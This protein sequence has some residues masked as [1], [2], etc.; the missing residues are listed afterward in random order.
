MLKTIIRLPDGT[1]ISSG[2]SEVNAIKEVTITQCVNSGEDLTIGSTCAGALEATLITPGGGL[3]IPADA[4]VTVLKQDGDNAPVQIGVYDLE[5]PTR[6]SANT[7][8]LTG[9]DPVAKL[10]K[11]L[12]DWLNSLSGWPYSLVDFAGKVCDACS[13]EFKK[14]DV[15][16]GS[17][18]VPQF[19]RSAVT[20]RQIMQWIGEICCRFCRADAYGNIE[21]AWYEHSGKRIDPDGELYY[22][23]NGLSYEDYETELVQAVQLRLSNSSDGALWPPASENSNSYIIVDNAIL[24]AHITES[25]IPVLNVIHEELANIKYTPCKVTV[26]ASLDIHAGSIVDIEDKNGAVMSTLVMTKTQKGRQD[27]LE[28]TGNR[29]RD[30]T[31]AMNSQ[32]KSAEAAAQ[33]VFAGMSQE[34]IFDKLTNGGTIPGLFMQDGQIYVNV[35]Y[36]AAGYINSDL[37]NGATLKI[38]KGASIAGWEVDNNSICKPANGNWGKGTFMSTGSSNSYEIGGSGKIPGWV[39]GAGGKFGVTL[40]GAVWVS[41]IH[42]TNGDVE[43]TSAEYGTVK[44]GNGRISLARDGKNRVLFTPSIVRTGYDPETE[45][46]FT[47]TATDIMFLDTDGNTVAGFRIGDSSLSMLLPTDVAGVKNKQLTMPVKW[48]YNTNIGWYIGAY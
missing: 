14:T 3:K 28:C 16:N 30:T 44:I 18:M 47:E 46:E 25:L 31:G 12:T 40:D 2:S 29:R 1:E 48:K 36:L 39:F 23:Q 27:T 11:D 21:F 26:P 42:V 24:N 17:F 32:Q 8:K 19:A 7:M 6:P 15:P 10:D 41:D 37:I 13:L 35:N 20:G 38:Q 45:E 9:Y 4:H 5:K 22:L 33:D 43:I 34:Q